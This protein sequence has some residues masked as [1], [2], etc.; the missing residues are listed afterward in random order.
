[1]AGQAEVHLPAGSGVG[2]EAELANAH[3]YSSLKTPTGAPTSLHRLVRGSWEGANC[4]APGLLLSSR[5]PG[6]QPQH[7]VLLTVP[8]SQP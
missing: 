2:V 4:P 3:I 5:T 6:T 7:H 1:M 8:K